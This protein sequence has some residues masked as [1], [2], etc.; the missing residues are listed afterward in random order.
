M[1]DRDQKQPAADA[2]E[3]L[4]DV[5]RNQDTLAG[6]V[7]RRSVFDHAGHGIRMLPVNRRDTSLIEE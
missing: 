3:E 4:P 5:L 2:G 7:F 6:M 1:A